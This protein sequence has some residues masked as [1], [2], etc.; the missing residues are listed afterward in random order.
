MI[1]LEIS[2]FELLS[3]GNETVKKFKESLRTFSDR[4]FCLKFFIQ[5]KNLRSIVVVLFQILTMF[6]PFCKPVSILAKY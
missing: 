3:F 5:L 4:Q 1:K 2:T 6:M